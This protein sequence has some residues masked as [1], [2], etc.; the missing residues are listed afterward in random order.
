MSSILWREFLS[1]FKSIKS[2]F[3]ILIFIGANLGLAKLISVFYGS[4]KNLGMEGSPYSIAIIF[5]TVLISPF[6]IFS[7]SHNSINEEIKSSTIRFIATK[8]K[9]RN[10]ILG[11]FLGMLL[12]WLLTLIIASLF[13]IFYSHSFY[14]IEILLS[15]IFISYFLSL[16][17]LIS[18]IINSTALTNFLGIAISLVMTILGVWSATSENVLLKIYS[19]ISPYYYFFETNRL[20]SLIV[21]LHIVVFLI[22]S[23]ILFK[24]RDL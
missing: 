4:L 14:I 5:V 9:R 8:T 16:S 6:F 13:M 23:I 24:R 2:I 17:I 15:L 11:K 10:I 7:L 18:T 12:F 19:F 22:I 1:S 21:L 3:T 20:L